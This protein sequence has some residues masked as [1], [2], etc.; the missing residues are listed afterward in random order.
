MS[1]ECRAW[2]DRAG[3]A[4]SIKNNQLRK[5]HIEKMRTERALKTVKAGAQKR[6]VSLREVRK[7]NTG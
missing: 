7:R 4:L 2:F 6:A 5:L 3:I 1:K